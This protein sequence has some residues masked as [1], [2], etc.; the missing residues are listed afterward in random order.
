MHTVIKPKLEE[1]KRHAFEKQVLEREMA[2]GKPRVSDFY[3]RAEN[4]CKDI[5]LF[6]LRPSMKQ[7]GEDITTE[8]IQ[9]VN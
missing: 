3:R 5:D 9:I 8:E 6:T 4:E 1:T 7:V 2:K